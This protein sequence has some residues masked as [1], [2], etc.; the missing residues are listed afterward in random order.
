MR[1][2]TLNFAEAVGTFFDP[3][4]YF[5]NKFAIPKPYKALKSLKTLLRALQTLKNPPQKKQTQACVDTEDGLKEWVPW[6]QA[7]F[8][9]SPEKAKRGFRVKGLGFRV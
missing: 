6:L 2:A 7:A 5:I 1:H 8:P 3:L 4:Q 9:C